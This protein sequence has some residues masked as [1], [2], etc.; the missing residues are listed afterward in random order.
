MRI[1]RFHSYVWAGCFGCGLLCLILGLPGT[2]D[3]G[4]IMET[5]ELP[6]A[7][8][9]VWDMATM[10]ASR[11]AGGWLPLDRAISWPTGHIRTWDSPSAL[12]IGASALGR[13]QLDTV[14]D[15]VSVGGLSSVDR[16]LLGWALRVP[17]Y[18]QGPMRLP[19]AEYMLLVPQQLRITL[20]PL[21]DEE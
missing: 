17:V 16:L 20:S 10:G 18:P 14:W 9:P 7:A 6:S 12:R 13:L 5:M 2:V 21:A 19:L 8:D 15:D 3:G 4:I 11:Y 1:M